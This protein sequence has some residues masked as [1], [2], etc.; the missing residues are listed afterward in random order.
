MQ[1]STEKLI[2]F[3]PSQ[4]MQR[5]VKESP[6]TRFLIAKALSDN[7]NLFQNFANK[8]HA[9]PLQDGVHLHGNKDNA[10]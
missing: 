9:I 7:T 10:V 6:R 8:I 3:Y 2:D 5:V 4:F 1:E